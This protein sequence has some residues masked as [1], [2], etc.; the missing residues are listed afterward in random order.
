VSPSDTGLVARRAR[1]VEL[2]PDPADL[3][4]W[5][6]ADVA[7]AVD[8]VLLDTADLDPA[9]GE[10]VWLDEDRVRILARFASF[11]FQVTYE[12]DGIYLLRTGEG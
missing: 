8:V 12:S 5:R 3:T 9:T 7:G 2:P 6:V 4:A 11:G 1:V 10:R